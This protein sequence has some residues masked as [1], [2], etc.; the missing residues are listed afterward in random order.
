MET[1]DCDEL[2]L[3][4]TDPKFILVFVTVILGALIFSFALGVWNIF[5]GEKEECPS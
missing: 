3:G 4:F 1:E 5:F 2:D